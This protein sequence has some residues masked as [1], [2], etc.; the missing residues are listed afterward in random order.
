[1]GNYKG[2][3]VLELAQSLHKEGKMPDLKSMLSPGLMRRLNPD[4]VGPAAASFVGYLLE[5][6]GAEKFLDLH[7]EAN[8]ANSPTE[9]ATAFELVYGVSIVQVEA[10]WLKL[11]D[12]LD[13]SGDI[14]AD[15]TSTEEG[16]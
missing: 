5:M 14:G 10:E 9:F 7:R 11:L 2:A 16:Q 1:M 15:S 13:F 6:G 4:L 8:A 3:P 12:R